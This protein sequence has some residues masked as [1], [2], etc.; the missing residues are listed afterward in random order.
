[1]LPSLLEAQDPAYPLRLLV[2]FSGNGTIRNSWLPERASGRVT[3]M[4]RILAPLSRHL[5][6]LMVVD[7]MEIVAA[8]QSYQ[9]KSGFHGHERGLGAILTGMPLNL[10]TMV[11][12]SG[13][14]QGI[15]VDNFI[16]N[17]LGDESA[18]GN[19]AVGLLTRRHGSGDYN[20]D[21][22]SYLGDNDPKFMEPDGRVLFNRIFGEASGNLEA[23]QRLTDRR[24]SVLDF[25]RDDMRR[26]E[27]RISSE[28]RVRLGN[29]HEAFRTLER[30]LAEPAPTCEEPALSDPSSWTDVN[31]IERILDFQFQQT[32]KALECDRTRVVSMQFGAGL[33]GVS[34]RAADPSVTEGWH[35]A[36]HQDYPAWEEHMVM[37]NTYIAEKLAALLDL[38]DAV[39]EGTGTLLD[40]SIVL[41]VNELGDGNAHRYSEAPLVMAGG[42]KG[43]FRTGGAFVDVGGASNNDLLISLCHAFGQTD[44]TEFGLP[45]LSTGPLEA[46][47]A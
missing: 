18:L 37:M 5:P 10:G 43:F 4:S 19:L 21:T 11:E 12:G 40:H 25:L 1:M 44:V 39:P 46:L 28:D 27:T 13:Y 22:M 24:Q 9:P 15:S 3:S 14:A 36:S 30:Q 41:W 26:L 34:L 33:G 29:H 16:A 2:F 7:G 23:Y 20:R 31:Q 45:E 8:N 42:G 32:V 38:M 47:H 35:S 17:R 6:K